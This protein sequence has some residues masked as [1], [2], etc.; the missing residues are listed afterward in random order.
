MSKSLS[1]NPSDGSHPVTQLMQVIA[2]G[3]GWGRTSLMSHPDALIRACRQLDNWTPPK[4]HEAGRR[5][6]KAV[7]ELARTMFWWRLH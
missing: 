2:V 6:V 4:T 3:T 5:A 1:I 7:P